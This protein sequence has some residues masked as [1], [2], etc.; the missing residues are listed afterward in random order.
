MA[1][2]LLYSDIEP[3]AYVRLYVILVLF[4]VK[5]YYVELPIFVLRRH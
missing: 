3:S 1:W 4:A 2:T 5:L